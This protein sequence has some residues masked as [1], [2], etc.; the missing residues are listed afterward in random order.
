[1]IY[2]LSALSFGPVQVVAAILLVGLILA[3]ISFMPFGY[4]FVAAFCSLL[5]LAV[6]A[7]WKVLRVAAYVLR[8][9]AKAL[10]RLLV[11]LFEAL[12]ESVRTR[13]AVRRRKREIRA[14]ERERKKIAEGETKEISENVS[15][16]F[17][18]SL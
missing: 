11:R 8:T 1:M 18:L 2:S 14:E 5:V 3:L 13:R 12:G 15:E 16:S 4:R 6:K 10:A 17:S 7:L 9:A